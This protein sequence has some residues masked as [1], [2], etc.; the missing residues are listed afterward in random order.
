MQELMQKGLK[1]LQM[2]KVRGHIRCWEEG[3]R[4]GGW[5]RFEGR[6]RVRYLH[7]NP[8]AGAPTDEGA[9]S[10][11]HIGAAGYQEMFCWT[12]LTLCRGKPSSASF[13]SSTG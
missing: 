5:E 11:I 4:W 6:G 3:G 10:G 12:V 2:L 7:R 9:G 1:E 13:T 8:P